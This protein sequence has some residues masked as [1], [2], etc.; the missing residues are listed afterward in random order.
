MALE[1]DP[2]PK[3]TKG[4]ILKVLLLSHLDLGY[5]NIRPPKTK[6]VLGNGMNLTKVFKTN[7]PYS[8]YKYYNPSSIC[9]DSLFQLNP[10]APGLTIFGFNEA[11]LDHGSS[12][13]FLFYNHSVIR[14]HV[15]LRCKPVGL[16]LLLC[17]KH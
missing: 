17:R 5:E 3:P 15:G 10:D 4:E 8:K 13:S 16:A 2:G 6:A 12:T 9:P 14:Q 11:F 1:G 7:K